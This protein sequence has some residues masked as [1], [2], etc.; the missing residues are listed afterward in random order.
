MWTTTSPPALR[1]PFS[2]AGLVSI[3]GLGRDQIVFGAAALAVTVAAGQW[4]WLIAIGV[5]PLL[6]SI[7]P[8][9]VMYA[10]GICMHRTGSSA[11]RSATTETPRPPHDPEWIGESPGQGWS[12]D[13][14]INQGG[15]T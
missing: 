1:R 4:N 7:A 13:Q 9:A 8:C 14:T 6:V 2:M 3:A 10:V 5:A 15:V 12:Q 11:R